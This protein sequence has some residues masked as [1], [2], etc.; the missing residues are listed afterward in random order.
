MKTGKSYDFCC[1]LTDYLTNYV[2]TMMRY[3]SRWPFDTKFAESA[4]VPYEG[5]ELNVFKSV[6]EQF[7]KDCPMLPNSIALSVLHIIQLFR[8]RSLQ[9]R[10]SGDFFFA[11]AGLSF[12]TLFNIL[13][14]G[15]NTSV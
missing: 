9:Q 3:L 11:S 10:N 7:D 12:E 14:F 6:C 2:I 13:N 1:F 8:Q 15:A 4:H 5:F